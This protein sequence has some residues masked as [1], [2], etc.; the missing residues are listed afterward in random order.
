M[1]PEQ[2]NMSPR[3]IWS[4]AAAFEDWL[5]SAYSQPTEHYTVHNMQVSFAAGAAWQAARRAPAA[6]VPQGWKI[7]EEQHVAAVKVLQ[8]ASGVDGLP[9]RMLDAMLAAAPQPPEAATSEHSQPMCTAA[10]NGA[11]REPLSDGEIKN[12]IA[13]LEH[14]PWLN[15][16]GFARAIERAHGIE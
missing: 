10:T 1:T 8:R 7:T 3:Q 16:H 2:D 4:A 11:E 6:P 12:I 15:P 9:Q 14:S 13:G 5:P